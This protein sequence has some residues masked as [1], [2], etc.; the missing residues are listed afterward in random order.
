VVDSGFYFEFL[1]PGVEVVSTIIWDDVVADI[2]ENIFFK[3]DCSYDPDGYL[4]HYEWDLGDGDLSSDISPIHAYSA[5]GTYT[6]TLTVMD[7]DE[8]QDTDTCLV[9]IINVGP[10]ADA[11]PDQTAYAFSSVQ[12]DG[13]GSYDIG[14]CIVDYSWDFGDGYIGSGV[15]PTHT[16]SYGGT[17]T[18]TLTVT[19]NHGATDTDTCL[20]DI[21]FTPDITYSIQYLNPADLTTVDSAGIHFYTSGMYPEKY[22][23]IPFNQSFT[24]PSSDYGTYYLYNSSTPLHFKV[25]ITNNGANAL[26][27]LV[28][29]TVQERHNDVTIW[30]SLGEI[31]LYKGQVMDGNSSEYWIIPT[32]GPGMSA[33]LEGFYFAEGRG[34]G[35]DQT[36]LIIK[37]NG[38]VIVDD[39]EAGVYCPP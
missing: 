35:L 6:V 37:M 25:T 33:T 34:W 7:D 39:P 36:H 15:Q 20:V 27:N 3:G 14:G 32:L 24:I 1:D 29:K 4:K 2:G 19:D 38:D 16:Y 28:V 5:S 18:V 17:Y 9:T 11:G 13:S 21:L 23:T 31:T 26:N 22:H 8:V 30:D 10:V 12:L